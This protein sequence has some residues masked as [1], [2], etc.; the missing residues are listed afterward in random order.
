MNKLKQEYFLVAMVFLL[1]VG[2]ACAKEGTTPTISAPS[3]ILTDGVTGQVLYTKNANVRRPVASTTK[4]MTAII[5]IENCDMDEIVTASKAAS[6]TPF[7]SLHLQPGEEVKVG[8]LLKALLIRSANDT[9]VALAEHVGGTMDKFVQ[10]MNDKAKKI[11]AK[12]THFVTP[13][14]L[15]APDHYSTAYDLALITRYALSLPIFNEI[16]CCRSARIERSINTQDVLVQSKSK[17]LKDYPGA[18]GV[19]SGYIK[20]A[21]YCYVGS[22]TRDGLRLVSVVLK[23]DDSQIDTAALMDYGFA[24]Y[25]RLIL[26]DC[27]QTIKTIEIPGGAVELGI[28]SSDKLQISVKNGEQDKARTEVKLNDL[29]APIRKGDKVGTITALIGNSQIASVDLEAANDVD[30]S[31]ASIAWPWVRSI[32]LLTMLSVGVACGRTT[33]K[34]NGRSRSRFS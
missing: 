3:A 33:A 9:A 30:E 21:G 15:Y 2:V 19:K 29:H 31:L 28:I 1:C 11:G 20:E 4:I 12:D 32:G 13:N 24:N 7:T 10:L 27:K 16:V 22:A 26:A 14:G 6:E 17:F 18:N 25:K 5:V 23:S 8:E 34:S